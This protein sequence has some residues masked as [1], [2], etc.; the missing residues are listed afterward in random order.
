MKVTLA[1]TAALLATC[2]AAA[3]SINTLAG[4]P[5]YT[6]EPARVLM[7]SAAAVHVARSAAVT[8]SVTFIAEWAVVWTS[9]LGSA[10]RVEQ[11]THSWTSHD[12]APA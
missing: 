2:T 5:V 8:A 9:V 3:E 11:E 10:L 7:L 6:G 1:V 4:S 12:V